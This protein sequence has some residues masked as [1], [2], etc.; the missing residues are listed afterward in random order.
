MSATAPTPGTAPTPLERA[1]AALVG[2]PEHVRPGTASEYL[3]DAAAQTWGLRGHA[4]AVALPGSPEEVAA[5][6]AWCYERGVPVTV[7]GGGT[8]YA[9]GAMPEGGVVLALERLTRIRSFD[10]LQWRLEVE[11]GVRTGDLRRIVRQSGLFF[12]PDPGAAEQSQIGG[13]VATNAGGP[14]AFKY[15]VTGAYVTG[16]EAVVP[17]GD[18]LRI[19]GA[20]R[21]D[22]AAYDLKSLL[23]GSEGT[24]GVITSIWLRLIPAPEAFLPVA[25]FYRDTA[26][27]C[28]ALET[29]MGSGLAVAALE[30]LDVGTLAASG[31]AFPGDGLAGGPA[32]S[33]GIPEGAG[34]LVI[35]EAD[36]TPEEARRLRAEVLEALA[37]GALAVHAP[38]TT[39]AVAELWRWRDLVSGMVAAKLGGKAGEDIV[40]P[41]DRLAE[42]IAATVEIGLRHGFAACSW[43][44]AGDGNLHS[45]FLL[46]RLDPAGEIAR[47]RV[48]AAELFAMAVSLGGSISGEHGIGSLKAGHLEAQLTPATYRLHGEVKRLFDPKNLLNPG[49]KR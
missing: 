30:Y 37:D 32:G 28:A 10:P 6:L 24:L 16:I 22:V 1:L 4:D 9:G 36:G 3:V 44:H 2:G 21:K 34:F 8:G 39:A 15:G 14:H 12:P 33:P 5:V 19:G 46:P 23:I 27:G 31:H 17:P 43:G 11:A 45:N 38:E 48:A 35:A 47:V 18:L 13:N 29:V 7:R 20:Q 49:K 40:V 25:A 26:A 41:F 42:A